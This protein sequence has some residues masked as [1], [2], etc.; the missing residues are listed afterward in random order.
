MERAGL[1]K[2]THGGATGNQAA[3]FEPSL[4]QKE[5]R[6]KNEKAAIGRLAAGLI[7]EGETVMLDA[8]S[9]TLQIARQFRQRHGITVVNNAVNIAW[10]WSSS[11]VEVT[12][13]RGNVTEKH[14]GARGAD[15]ERCARWVA[16]GQVVPGGHRPG[17]ETGHY[18]SQSHRGS[19]EESHAG[20]RTGGDSTA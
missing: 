6:F 10:E 4:V 3:A 19:D 17:L 1:L 2:R 8:G 9:T 13:T 18:Q 20:R 16:R 5:D 14:D 11:D 15:C 7:R 12:L